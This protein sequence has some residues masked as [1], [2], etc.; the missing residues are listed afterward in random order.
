MLRLNNARVA[1]KHH[2]TIVDSTQIRFFTSAVG[3]FLTDNTPLLWDEPIE[4]I[5]LVGLITNAAVRTELEKCEA[6]V[7]TQ[8]P[9]IAEISIA[10]DLVIS[11][12][13]SKRRK[14]ND[15]HIWPTAHLRTE[16]PEDLKRHLES[17]KEF[18]EALRDDVVGLT[19]QLDL[20]R[21]ATFN[22][23]SVYV[24]HTMNGGVHTGTPRPGTTVRDCQE[25]FDFVV[26]AALKIQ[27]IYDW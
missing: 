23:K 22:S 18:V 19:Y 13:D 21:L 14:I 8:T 11:I 26:D 7:R 17:I 9:C 2:G 1:F 24:V 10:F 6:L 5:S 15:P 16:L 25:C 4:S 3:D 12:A 27:T 20:K